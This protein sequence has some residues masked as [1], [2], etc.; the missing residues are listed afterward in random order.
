[1]IAMTLAEVAAAVGG[2]LEG[3]DPARRVSSVSTDSRRIAHGDLF[4]A[5]KGPNHDGHHYVPQALAAGAA[6]AVVDRPVEAAGARIVAGE[7]LRALGDLAREV[8]RRAGARVAA[9]GGAV[10]KTTTK[11]I[12]AS[13][14]RVRRRTVATEA[15]LNNLIGVPLTILRLDRRTEAAVVEAGISVPGEMARLAEIIEPDVAVLTAL[16]A[17]HLEGLGSIEAAVEEEAALAFGAARRGGTVVLDADSPFYDGLR[18]R[19]E[20]AGGRV[21]GVSARGAEREIEDLGLDGVRFRYRGV[22]IHLRLP[23]VH[24]VTNALLAAAAAESLGL[25]AL[26]VATGL[27]RVRPIAERLRIED[28]GGVCLID[29]AYNANP[30][31]VAAALE[32]LKRAEARRRIFVFAD[33]LELGAE[34]ARLHAEVG[35]RA[36]EAGVGLLLWTGAHAAAT[37]E[38]AARRG[39]AARRLADNEALL[40]DLLRE[41][42]PGDAVLVKASHGMRLHE[43]AA[44]F[45]RAR[46]APAKVEPLKRR[47]R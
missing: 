38:A 34:S 28:L 20:A 11:E 33:M 40:A 5:L 43:V 36:A 37:A 7:T 22:G 17:E 13:I 35:E 9:I 23:G 32:V 2:R 39:V 4:V 30:L 1:M 46:R 25:D 24:S 18:R 31:S 19:L 3:G 27:E 21:V 14:L 44:A 15:N 41:A 10:G 16:G 45:R 12:L 47:T 29:D 6:A 42:R 8:R 26:D